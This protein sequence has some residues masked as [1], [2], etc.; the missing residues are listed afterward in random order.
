MNKLLTNGS[1]VK[2]NNATMLIVGNRMEEKDG[3]LHLAY[4]G[5]PF[6]IGYIDK[7]SIVEFWDDIIND[8]LYEFPVVNDINK[9]WHDGYEKLS[10]SLE[11]KSKEEAE[12]LLR[13]I[14]G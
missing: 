7:E 1:V 8:V 12:K 2:L 3:K 11:G 9:D 5:V 14:V 6:P 13:D 10:A 4:L